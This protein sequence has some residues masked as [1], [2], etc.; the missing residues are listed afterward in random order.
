MRGGQVSYRSR[1]T[2]VVLQP[3]ARTDSLTSIEIPA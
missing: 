2:M 1:Q 3:E